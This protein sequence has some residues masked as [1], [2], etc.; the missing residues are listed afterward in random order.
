[1]TVRQAYARAFI[2]GVFIVWPIL[3]ALLAVIAG[4][5]A[6]VGLIEGWGVGRGI[7]FGFITALTIGYGDHVPT[8]ATTQVLA[9]LTG[10]AGIAMTALLAAIAV[11]AFQVTR[12]V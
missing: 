6:A 7:Y 5:G 9:V 3:S 12:G 11:H 4:I 1:M 8:H 10:F 2:H